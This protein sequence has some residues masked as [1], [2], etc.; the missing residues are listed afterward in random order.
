MSQRTQ[1][2]SK[3]TETVYVYEEGMMSKDQ[4]WKWVRDFKV[5]MMDVGMILKEVDAFQF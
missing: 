2:Q 3:F 4:V 1:L 5:G